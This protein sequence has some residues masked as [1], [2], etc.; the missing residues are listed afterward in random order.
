M[1]VSM[2]SI[3]NCNCKFLSHPESSALRPTVPLI[4]AESQPGASPL[5]I[6]RWGQGRERQLHTRALMVE[7][8]RLR[9]FVCVCDYVCLEIY[10]K[11]S[12]AEEA[13]WKIS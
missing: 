7:R 5:V 3:S 12:R 6:D 4:E 8:G 9:V 10:S 2:T 11:D 1:A 13:A